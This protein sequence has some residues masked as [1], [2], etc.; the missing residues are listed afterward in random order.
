[1]KRSFAMSLLRPTLTALLSIIAT[2]AF[3]AVDP[4][5]TPNR[6]NCDRCGKVESIKQVTVR[7]QWTPLGSTAS[8][9]SDGNPSGVAVYQIGKGFTNQ[10]QVLLG[11]AGG[12]AY[13]TKPNELNTTRWEV[14]VRMDAGGNRT[15]TQNYEPML[16]EGDR[17]RVLGKQIELLQ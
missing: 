7:D 1:M 2:A 10:G 13:R 8:S 5:T 9:A 11:A 4:V 16:R 17:V 14:T 3:G 15:M 6:D 12:G